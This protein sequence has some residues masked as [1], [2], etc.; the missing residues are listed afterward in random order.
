MRYVQSCLLHRLCF[1]VDMFFV[2]VSVIIF[3]VQKTMIDSE[4]SVF[5][6]GCFINVHV[7]LVGSLSVSVQLLP[8]LY[9][10]LDVFLLL[11]VSKGSRDGR[12]I[13]SSNGG[14]GS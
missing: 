4:Y 3:Y 2:M 12:S 11:K 10:M 5:L 7:L 6:I 8:I 13:C 1:F 14:S 9:G